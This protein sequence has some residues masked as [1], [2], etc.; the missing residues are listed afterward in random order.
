MILKV[1]ELAEKSL[2][3]WK[4]GESPTGE[5]CAF[6]DDAVDK[7]GEKRCL[8][9]KVPKILCNDPPHHRSLYMKIIETKLPNK[10]KVKY[11]DP[12]LR[13]LM[14][15]ALEDL[16]DF[17]QLKDSTFHRIVEAIL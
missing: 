16:V 10:T 17:E 6:C 12:A 1:K 8:L 15:K 13:M 9:C 2:K 11:I 3:K 14:I 4:D 5:P 7:N